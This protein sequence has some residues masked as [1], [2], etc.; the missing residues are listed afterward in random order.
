M[1]CRIACRVVFALSLL[2]P[3]L[4]GAQGRLE[5][6]TPDSFQSGQGLIVGWH[7]NAGRIDVEVDGAIVV[8]ASYGTLRYDT[9]GV[10][11][12]ANN[13]FGFQ[14]NWNNL[15]DG[16][17]TVRVLA[18][19]QEFGRATFT[20]TTLGVDVLTGA[21]GSYRVPFAGKEVTLTW[22]EPLQNFVI[23]GST[24]APASVSG[25]WIISVDYASEDCNFLQ[26]PGDLPSHLSSTVYVSQNG[27]SLSV[28]SGSAILTGQLQPNGDFS[29]T[30]PPEVQ[31]A[32]TCTFSMVAGYSGNFNAGTVAFVTS[33]DRVS[34]DCTGITLPCAVNY[35]GTIT[36][37][38]AQEESGA[39]GETS[40]MDIIQ[41][42]KD[43]MAGQMK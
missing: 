10:C 21:S 32:L 16:Q 37:A 31:T 39:P 12:D 35:T 7:C 20:V 2:V 4:A 17:H 23:T 27:S 11:G 42:A 6:P 13:G 1:P 33:V 34:G 8:Q 40:V 41:S 18:D 29:V 24:T 28:Q 30:S 38:A 15:G 5:N 26:I 19:G 25:T 36:R 14:L 3:A 9:Q 43:A 22:S